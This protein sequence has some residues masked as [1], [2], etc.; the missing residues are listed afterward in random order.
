MHRSQ[1]EMAA[2]W[3]A[4]SNANTGIT[5]AGEGGCIN[6]TNSP[7]GHP[8]DMRLCLADC[9]EVMGHMAGSDPAIH[10]ANIFENRILPLGAD[11]KTCRG[12]TEEL[13]FPLY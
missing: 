1:E 10:S 6:T 5:G 13:R 12:V 11:S 7:T 3:W 2:M 9:W 8:C 4:P